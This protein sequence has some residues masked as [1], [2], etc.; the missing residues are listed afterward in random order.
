MR[1]RK[2]D[3]DKAA[4]DMLSVVATSRS[5]TPTRFE[6]RH[7]CCGRVTQIS[8]DGIGHR[9][10]GGATQCKKC[11][12]LN[13]FAAARRVRARERL[14]VLPNYGVTPPE[15]PVPRL[16]LIGANVPWFDRAA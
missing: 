1:A 4:L 12:G 7:R 5:G 9:I 16:E 2:I 6:V 10:L 15:W 14:D 8:R 11:A 3:W 13:N